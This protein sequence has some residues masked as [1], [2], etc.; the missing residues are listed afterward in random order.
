M[1]ENN[2]CGMDIESVF[3]KY[4]TTVYRLAFARTQNKYDAEDILQT[5]F[6]RLC[7]CDTVFSDDEHIKAWLIKVTVNTSKNLL[8]S[9]FHRLTQP[10]PDQ[11]LVEDNPSFEVYDAVRALPQKYRTVVHLFYYEGYTCAEIARILGTKEATV[12]TRLKRSRERLCTLLKG[13]N[14][15]V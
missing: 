13:E 3:D 5:V 15:D 8:S 2:L 6:L 12:K 4:Y 7:K 10:M 14:F 9:A 11:I 1:N